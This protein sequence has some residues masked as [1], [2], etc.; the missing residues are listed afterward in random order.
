MI[1][2][3]QIIKS[4][5][6]NLYAIGDLHIGSI[7][8]DEKRFRKYSE[9]IKKDNFAIVIIAGDVIDDDRPTTR[10]LRKNMFNDRIEAFQAE[11]MQHLDYLDNK[12]IPL[13]SFLNANNC[14]GMLDGDHYRLYSNGLTSTQ[15]ICSRLKVPYLGDGHAIINLVLSHNN[16]NFSFPIYV[17]HGIGYNKNIGGTVNRNEEFSDKIEGIRCFIRAHSHNCVI[18]N[19]T[20]YFYDS[21]WNSLVDK[22]VWIINAGSFRN[23]YKEGITD[24][25]EQK[26][27]GNTNKIQ[28]MLSI[29]VKSDDK[30]S[31]LVVEG[32]YI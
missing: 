1:I 2:K 14:I 15:Y 28:A 27:Y 17:R 22:D 32:H 8:F 4:K 30:G 20:K 23:G 16:K 18:V 19:K 7:N 26:E 13:L 12:V 29:K 24:Y 5:Q 21:A 6:V 31:H 25:A 11:D 9:I 3:K 10:L